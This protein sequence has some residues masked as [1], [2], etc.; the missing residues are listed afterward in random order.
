MPH[1]HQICHP[2]KL[3]WFD[4]GGEGARGA[5]IWAQGGQLKYLDYSECLGTSIYLC[6]CISFI[7][8]ELSTYTLMHDGCS[9]V[10]A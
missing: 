10:Q 1:Y 7:T 2:D 6:I 5:A 3:P 9:T 4:A 8:F